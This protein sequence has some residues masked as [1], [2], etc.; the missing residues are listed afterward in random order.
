MG[1]WHTGYM[2]FHEDDGL[3][4]PGPRTPQQFQCPHCE[5]IFL[6]L[7]VLRQHRF[8]QHPYITPLL[9]IKGLEAGKT[10]V[11]LTS[12]V[13]AQDFILE[14]T[15]QAYINGQPVDLGSVSTSLAKRQQDRITLVLKNTGTSAEF[16]LV[17]AIPTH[18]DLIG[19]EDAFMRLAKGKILS[20]H[21]IEAFIIDC[22][23]FS[24]ASDY[25]DGICSYLYGVLTKERAPETVIPY[26]RYTDKFNQSMSKLTDYDRPLSRLIRGL[27]SFHFNHFEDAIRTASPRLYKIASTFLETL[28]KTE[29]PLHLQ[30][31]EHSGAREDLLTDN[32]TLRILKW[33][34]KPIADLA[35]EF[36][37]IES[38]VMK[39]I[40]EY[41]KFK[42]KILL[43]EIHAYRGD[44]TKARS[45]ARELL[46]N[47]RSSSWAERLL[48][49]LS[50]L[51]SS[52]E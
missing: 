16:D 5:D 49:R 52:N 2:E 23:P 42:L 50:L 34:E 37:Q 25:C 44:T 14:R 39:D 30:V 9:L 27:V 26:E 46:T 47:N 31:T 28:N 48:N 7:D 43:A 20:L 10:T 36:P 12:P 41:D 38:F 18:D 17:F 15:E 22:S 4:E 21:T 24:S 32:E 13:T 8:N 29:W 1:F 51:E 45:Y 33:A 6:S 40:P 19:I 11:R 3:P 35:I